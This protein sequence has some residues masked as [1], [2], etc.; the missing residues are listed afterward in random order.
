MLD[1]HTGIGG[2]FSCLTNVGLLPAMARGLDAREIRAG[3]REVVDA[4][5]AA[6]T[7]REFAPSSAPP[8]PSLCR[9]RRIRTLVLMPYADRLGR[10]ADWYVQLWAESLGKK[11]EGTSPIGALGPL[12]Q[13]SQLQL[14]MD[15]PRELYITIV[16]TPTEGQAP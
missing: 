8:S 4:M 10:L 7:P 12:D 3:A 14:Y 15:G 11:G 5:M 16:R 13:H 9:R 2:R 1:H 6:K